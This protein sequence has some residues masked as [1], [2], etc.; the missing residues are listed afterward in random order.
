MIVV[1]M[2]KAINHHHDKK[3]KHQ[4]LETFLISFR[5]YRRNQ[6]IK[7]ANTLIAI[8]QDPLRIPRLKI[9]NAA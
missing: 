1:I 7:K 5:L 6:L 3:I 9:L 8:A 4:K 2:N